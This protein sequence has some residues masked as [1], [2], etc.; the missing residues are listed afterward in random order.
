M[1]VHM[2]CLLS[3]T[4]QAESNYSFMRLSGHRDPAPSLAIKQRK[5]MS[6]ATQGK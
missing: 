5:G 3:L 6:K 4:N 2:P 1:G